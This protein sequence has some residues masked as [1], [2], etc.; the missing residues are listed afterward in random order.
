MIE[1]VLPAI[2]S[3]LVAAAVWFYMFYSSAAQQLAGIE[4]RAA[5]Q[6]RVRLRRMG[7]C[8]MILLA[9]AFYVGCDALNRHDL[10]LFSGMMLAVLALMALTLVLA[11]ID[12]RLT[13]KLRRDRG[14]N[15]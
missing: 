8:S 3:L 1:R 10:G 2:F 6:R 12:L 4:N 13:G 15:D 5:N 11:L 14:E 9:V 7:G